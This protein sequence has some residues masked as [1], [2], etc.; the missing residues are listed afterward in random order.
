LAFAG[1]GIGQLAHT[2]ATPAPQPVLLGL[3]AAAFGALLGAEAAT[4]TLGDAITRGEA[5]PGR[6]HPR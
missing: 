1:F 2:R 3:G 6:R 5:R 4:E